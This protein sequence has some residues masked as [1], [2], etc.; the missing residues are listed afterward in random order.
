MTGVVSLHVPK[1]AGTS[2]LALYRRGFGDGAVV[3]DYDD[4]PANPDS[5]SRIDP[6][7]WRVRR[8]RRLPDG[9]RVVHGHFPA[10][11]Y[12][13]VADVLRVTF[14]RHPVDNLVSI[15]CYWRRIPRQDSALHRRFL[16][17]ALGL[18]DMARLPELRWL[19]SRTY[20]GG[21]DMGRMDFIGCHENR[22]SDLARLGRMLGIA[23]DPTLHLNATE[24]EG[25][26]AERQSLLADSGLMAKLADIAADDIRFYER[27]A[28]QVGDGTGACSPG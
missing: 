12:D 28:V 10:C 24:P 21:F 13:L 25:D 23:L 6:G 1:A 27:H 18:L 9:A 14:L 3:M 22:T 8:P 11:K 16:D 19:Y 7:A 17:N 20:F 2:L 26:D 4:D 15:Y 5:P